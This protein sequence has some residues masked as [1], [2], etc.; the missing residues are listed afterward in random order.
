MARLSPA[1]AQPLPGYRL[2]HR[3]KMSAEAAAMAE[4]KIAE[5]MRRGLIVQ[6]HDD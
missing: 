4:F 3:T 5:D 2:M 6:P 1:L